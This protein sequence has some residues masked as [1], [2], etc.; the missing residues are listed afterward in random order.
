MKKL[1]LL[2][3]LCFTAN[4]FSAQTT[5]S[6][7][8]KNQIRN[9]GNEA[10]N[11]KNYALA[12][13]K[14]SDYLKQTNNQDSVVAFNCGVCADNIQKYNESA[15]YFDIAI[16]KGYNLA[17]AYVG[18]ASAFQSLKKNKEYIAT[19]T[20]AMK[21]VPAN[22]QIE[23]LYAIYYLKEGQKY[24]KANNIAQAEENYKH[25]TE[26]SLKKQKTDALYSL[27]IL[28]Y[29][30]GA[31]ILKKAT[32]LANSNKEKYAA[33]KEKADADFKKASEYLGEAV[34]VSPERPELAKLLN[35]VKASI[36]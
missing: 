25:A 2:L 24:Q 16:Q 20:E 19:L 21:A 13:Q 4:H 1:I 18:K 17:N 12:F 29:N 30:N 34:A 5:D 14:Y 33:E 11:A 6:V 22:A 26:V 28:F 3:A 7:Q 27:G 36:K 23:K 9:E 35:Q 8:I 10:L 32:P 31:N 15:H